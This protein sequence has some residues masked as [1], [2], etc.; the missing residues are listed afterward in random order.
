MGDLGGSEVVREALGEEGGNEFPESAAN[1]PCRGLSVAS[2]TFVY[3]SPWTLR[4]INRR[5]KE[6][7]P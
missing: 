7:K 1:R 6:M 4:V 2:E 5:G 3:V